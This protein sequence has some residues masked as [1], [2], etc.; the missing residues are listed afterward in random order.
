MKNTSTL[1]RLFAAFMFLF[2]I[3]SNSFGQS[4]GKQEFYELRVYRISDK[5]QEDRIDAYLKDAYIPALHSAG[6]SK[7]GVFKPIESDTAFGKL[8][9]VFIPFKT[10]EQFIQLPEVLNKDKVYVQAGKSFLDAPYNDPP[11]VQ[12]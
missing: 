12:I 8:V 11:F 3:A 5:S 4:K 2:I 1:Y 6:I 9:Y 7:V 10:I